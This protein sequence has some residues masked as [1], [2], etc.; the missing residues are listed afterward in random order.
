[1]SPRVCS[2][3]GSELMV[4]LL[5]C[6]RA[7]AIQEVLARHVG[8]IDI[9]Q[10]DFLVETLKLPQEWIYSA[11]VRPSCPLAPLLST[12]STHLQALAAKHNGDVYDEYELLLEALR[13]NEAHA[14]AVLELG[15]EAVIR[16]DMALLR[17]LFSRFKEH[18]VAD[19]ESGGK[20]RFLLSCAR[21]GA[22]DARQIFVDYADCVQELQRR[23]P[24]Q[25]L[26]GML[27]DLIHAVPTLAEKGPGL[28]LKV[29]V[30]EMQSR[31]TIIS[32]TLN[33]VRSSSS[34]AG[35]RADEVVG[36]H[37][38]AIR[39]STLQEADRLVWLKGA[40]A[41]FFADS[42]KLASATL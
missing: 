6:R 21:S 1:M 20:V 32:S 2:S 11:Q 3:V 4:R 19:W 24:T 14:I 8:D 17:K 35:V 13:P 5:A 30:S 41:A 22:D 15:P 16:N 7:K 23:A 26:S 38:N 31:L 25:R 39:P 28:K 33:E 29:A 34:R 36:Q 10:N 9:E 12:H 27:L 37:S 40:N 42:L 18:E